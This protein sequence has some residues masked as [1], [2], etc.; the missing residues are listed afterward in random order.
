[1]P[2]AK[3]KQTVV[4][5]DKSR[6]EQSSQKQNLLLYCFTL[7]LLLELNGKETNVSPVGKKIL[8]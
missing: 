2:D 6:L 3:N 4:N 8:L 1:M 7:Y 5:I